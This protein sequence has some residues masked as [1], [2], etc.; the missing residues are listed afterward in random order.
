[1][2]VLA[3]AQ[4]VGAANALVPVIGEL[5]RRGGTR[6]VTLACGRASKVFAAAGI[7]PRELE[8]PAELSCQSYETVTPILEATEPDVLL[9]GSG[10]GPTIDKVMLR[11]TRGTGIPSLTVLDM[12]SNYR[13]RFSHPVPDD[14]CLPTKVAVMDRLAFDEAVEVGLPESALAI[15]GQPHL[16]ALAKTYRSPAAIVRAAALRSRWLGAEAARGRT[17][18]VLFMSEAV[19]RDFGPDSPYY[20]GYTEIDALEGVIEAVASIEEHT[21]LNVVVVAK[22][23]PEESPETFHMGP[24]ATKRGVNVVTD[25]A[26]PV[27]VL[28]ADLVVGMTSMVL[29]EALIAGKPTISFQPGAGAEDAFVGTRMGVVPTASSSGELASVL[30]SSLQGADVSGGQGETSRLPAFVQEGSAARVADL[31][32]ELV[33]AGPGGLGSLQ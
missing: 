31:L 11:A 32:F 10:R 29:L 2:I 5:G 6:V 19:A 1:M 9:L 18:L 28:A 15:T 21:G 12:W 27:C 26:A 3:A 13:A 7:E 24:I 4:E 25:E 14:M 30:Q 23:H 16:E 33:D 8:T 17:R 20:P 22:L